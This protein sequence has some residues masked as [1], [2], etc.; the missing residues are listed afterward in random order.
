MRIDLKKYSNTSYNENAFWKNIP[1]RY[2]DA[3]LKK[4]KSQGWTKLNIRY[5]GPR[6][7]RDHTLKKNAVT[8][9]VY[10][11]D[12]SFNDT[13]STKDLYMKHLSLKQKYA[14]LQKTLVNT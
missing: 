2:L 5:R 9:S 11:R 1:I 10:V 13:H 3:V 4:L 14:K 8:F 12:V 6:F 7:G